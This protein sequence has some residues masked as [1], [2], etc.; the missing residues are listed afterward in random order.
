MKE[1]PF[2]LPNWDACQKAKNRTAL[3]QFIFMNEP[4]GRGS[5]RRFRK[6]L[7]ALVKE[8]RQEAINDLV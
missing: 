5:I 4:M 1:K 7:T 2:K 8:Q 6:E 3:Q